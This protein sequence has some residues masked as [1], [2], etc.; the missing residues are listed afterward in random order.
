MSLDF[1]GQDA[2]QIFNASRLHIHVP[3]KP[4]ATPPPSTALNSS[5]TMSA[6]AEDAQEGAADDWIAA[7]ARSDEREDAFYDESLPFYLLLHLPALPNLTRA[8]A[9]SLLL[10]SL[11]PSAHLT[12]SAELSYVEGHPSAR[13]HPVPILGDPPRRRDGTREPSVRDY[14]PHSRVDSNGIGAGAD[15]G[16]KVPVTPS[17]APGTRASDA[18]WVDA[19][20]VPVWSYAFVPMGEETPDEPDERTAEPAPRR[21][22]GKA[23]EKKFGDGRVWVGREGGDQGTG[24]WIGVWEFKGDVAFVRSELIQ[25]KLCLTV[26]VTFRDDPRLLELLERPS[27]KR[28]SVGAVA[29][30]AVDDDE[31]MIE[32]FDDVNLLEGLD[33]NYDLHLPASRLPLPTEAAPV[34]RDSFSH[35]RSSSLASLSRRESANPHRRSVSLAGA[36]T[37]SD[38]PLYPAVRR[39]FRRI[40]NVKSALSVRMRT[41][42]CPVSGFGRT[43]NRTTRRKWDDVMLEENEGLGMAMCVEVTGS[44][45]IAENIG[46]QIE[47]IEVEVTGG[48]GAGDVDVK[49]LDVDGLGPT[50]PITLN[51]ADQHNFLYAL[52]YSGQEAHATLDA[53]PPPVPIHVASSPSQ[54]FTS[55]M[56]DFADVLPDEGPP[57]PLKQDPSW[58]RNVGIVVRGRPVTLLGRNA[59]SGL[60]SLTGAFH[61]PG[62]TN[63]SSSSTGD[64]SSP[65][66]SFASRWN[67]TLD[68]S[69]FALKEGSKQESFHPSSTVPAHLQPLILPPARHSIAALSSTPNARSN[70]NSDTLEAVAGSKRYTISSL[71]ALAKSSPN[72]SRKTRPTS[73]PQRA[74]DFSSRPPAPASVGSPTPGATG[75]PKRFFSLPG[76]ATPHVSPRP[77]SYGE[78]SLPPKP[79]TPA[80]A[81]SRPYIPSV[82]VLKRPASLVRAMSSE[83]KR[84]SWTAGSSA[85]LPTLSSSPVRNAP[86]APDSS[87]GGL[88]LGFAAG[89]PLAEGYPTE[90]MPAVDQG[91]IL[92]SVAL[93]P[94][95]EVKPAAADLRPSEEETEDG[96]DGDGGTAPAFAF[97]VASRMPSADTKVLEQG[98][99]RMPVGLLDVFLV[100]VFVVNRS[101]SVKRFTV[102]VPA[103]RGE[104]TDEP[105]IATIIP[106][107]ND[108]RIGPL[109][110]QTCASVRLRFLAVRPGAHTLQELRLVDL[111][112]GQTDNLGLRI[113]AIFVILL[114]SLVGSLFPVLARRS[115]FLRA[116]VPPLVFE[117]AKLFGSGVIL[118]TGIIHL[119]EPAADDELGPMNLITNG[120]CISDAWGEYPYA[121]Q[122]MAVMLLEFGVIFHSLIIGLTLAVTGADEFNILFIVIIFHQMFEGLGLGTRLAFL[123]LPKSLEKLPLIG[124]LVYSC[125]TPIGMA[126]GLG[127]RESISMTS[128]SASIAAGVLDSTSAG[129]LIYTATLM[130]RCCCQITADL[131]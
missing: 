85:A 115:P 28:G 74:Y 63:G 92:V 30:T 13:Q 95:R 27:A 50:F 68:I 118:A 69:A 55:K 99:S 109:A 117:F 79:V 8:Q 60:R 44:G 84:E 121:V 71:A 93:I 4:T 2:V 10:P 105:R 104:S 90:L 24:S 38:A 120:G 61:V 58:A 96:Q 108:V 66:T 65:T 21:G 31:Y 67:C 56:G 111:A 25:P 51:P 54:R 32:S 5:T 20:G 125:V 1:D 87:M 112:T 9:T 6:E 18:E 37:N 126:I 107:E 129:I 49:I 35:R 103:R 48:A 62:S 124:A 52:S 98:L 113:G 14:R 70:R 42:P 16:P 116:R 46:F 34:P 89:A 26:T 123:T 131:V 81:G 29:D 19:T 82:G 45:Q 43:A 110:P 40:L 23:R 22:K 72:L 75:P 122:L 12:L 57:L 94:L 101:D 11:A 64:V 83:A 88:G 128:A 114:T 127:L 106:L 53:I 97:P 78:P 7:L 77:A 91:S 36:A 33:D 41:V 17:P 39:A 86:P 47:S 73:A 3:S 102:G 15:H 76:P 100:E 80:N 130:V 119:L 59:S